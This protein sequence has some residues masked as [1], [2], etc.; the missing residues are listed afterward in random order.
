M[1]AMDRRL[2]DHGQLCSPALAALPRF[3]RNLD[4]RNAFSIQPTTL[5]SRQPA[6]ETHARSRQLLELMLGP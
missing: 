5:S 4:S 6:P 3:S 2:P 1:P